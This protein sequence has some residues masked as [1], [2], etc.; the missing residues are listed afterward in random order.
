M[1]SGNVNILTGVHGEVSG[2]MKADVSL[3]QADVARVGNL[4][5]VTVYNVP[6]MSAAELRQILNGPGTTIGAFCNSGACLAPYW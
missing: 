2:A 3:Y 6:G 4:P 5:G 1:Y